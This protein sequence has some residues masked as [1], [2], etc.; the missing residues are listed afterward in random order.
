V[1]LR[2]YEQS[3]GFSE[4]SLVGR[5]VRIGSKVVVSVLERDPRCKMITLDPDTA[6]PSPE[7]LRNVAQN[8]DGMAGVYGAILVEG[9]LWV[10]DPA[11]EA[12]APFSPR[13][14]GSVVD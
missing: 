10:G 12:T 6:L 11:V 4:M 3:A 7:V 1:Q 13:I 5:S 9:T 2:E 8:H 14:F